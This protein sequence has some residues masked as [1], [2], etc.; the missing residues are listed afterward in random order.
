RGRRHDDAVR[1]RAGLLQLLDHRLHRRLL[2]A[3]G[4][5]DADDL[6][7]V[8][9]IAAAGALL[10][11]EA[12][13]DQRG[14]AGLAVAD[15]QLALTAADRDPR[16]DRLDARLQRLLDGLPPGHRRRTSFDRAQ[17]GVVG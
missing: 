13:D 7:G 16:V 5:V 6:V 17:I 11:D 12:V 14:L 10:V 4:D 9:R 15:D 2:L 3:D 8:L 1:H